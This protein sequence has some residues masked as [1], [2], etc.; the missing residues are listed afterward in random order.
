MF[1]VLITTWVYNC[2]ALSDVFVAV[3]IAK[4]PHYLGDGGRNTFPVRIVCEKA[5]IELFYVTGRETMFM[6]KCVLVGCRISTRL[7][8]RRVFGSYNDSSATPQFI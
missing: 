3:V 6:I 2:T 7:P 5:K 4:A 1:T 8:V